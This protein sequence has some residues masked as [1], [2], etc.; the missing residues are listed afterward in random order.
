MQAGGFDIRILR[1]DELA[2]HGTALRDASVERVGEGLVID[3]GEGVLDAAPF[4]AD[5]EP[6]EA[7]T[8]VKATAV[9]ATAEE[10]QNA[11]EAKAEEAG[12]AAETGTAEAGEEEG[13]PLKFCGDAL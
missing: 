6:E 5:D 13:T 4:L 12:A 10:E 11:E 9:E 8:A 7:E 2:F 3:L 1:F